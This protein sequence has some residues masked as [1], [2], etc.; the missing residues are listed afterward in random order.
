MSLKRKAL[1]GLVWTY[2]QQFSTQLINFV[3]NLVLARI[4]F[5]SD[6]GTISLLTVFISISNVIIGGGLTSSLIRKKDAN[7]DDYNTVFIFN[8]VTALLMYTLIFSVS[9]LIENFYKADQLSLVLRVYSIC[10]IISSFGIVQRGIL[11]KQLNFKKETLIT[12]P[13]IIISGVVGVI[14]AYTDFGVWSL[15]WSAIIK[16]AINVLQLWLYSDWKPNFRFHKEKFSFHFQFGYKYTSIEIIRTVFTNIYPMILGRGFSLK[17][18]GLFKQADVLRLLPYSNIVS[19]VNRVAFPLYVEVQD[20]P[21]R[22]KSLH[23]KLTLILFTILCPV[24]IYMA[25]LSEDILILFFS[26][27]WIEAA[28]FLS[29]LSF[30]SLLSVINFN[31]LNVLSAKGKVNLILRIEIIDKVIF[32]LL[33]AICLYFKLGIIMLLLAEIVRGVISAILKEFFCSKELGTPF[34]MQ[35]LG[36]LFPFVATLISGFIVFYCHKILAENTSLYFI[37]VA[38]PVLVGLFIYLISIWLFRR[39]LIK[40]AVNIITKKA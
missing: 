24:F 33:V 14:M 11:I 18:V 30:G 5:P 31:N 17:E 23:G 22:L 3:I 1:S 26:K 35:L 2:G 13:S 15:V 29:I 37:R 10:L 19:S 16:N 9:P 4:L 32:L 6:F 20:D 7:K 25:I 39:S 36:L 21:V 28:P 40:D 12:L 27:K 38:V 8:I 34:G